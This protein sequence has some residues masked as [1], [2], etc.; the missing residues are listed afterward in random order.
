MK[1]LLVRV[2]N[3]LAV[4]GAFSFVALLATVALFAHRTL[5]M[6]DDSASKNDVRFVLNWS[7]LGDD[8]IQA[9]VHSHVSMRSFTGDHFDAYAIRVASLTEAELTGAP[10]SGANRWVRGD[11]V[12]PVVADAVKFLESAGSEAPWLPGGDELLTAR[13]YI[14]VWSI[15]LRG[16]RDVTAA[17]IILARPSDRMIF[18]ASI[19]G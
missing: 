7:Q 18:Y 17:E 6:K 4:W 19:K 16:R 15:E 1:G 5:P 10:P 8:R 12:D 14:W 2:R 13:Y 11:A 3:V 9:V